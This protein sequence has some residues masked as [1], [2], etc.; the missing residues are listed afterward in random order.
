MGRQAFLPFLVLAG[1][2]MSACGS[3]DVSRALGARCED[4]G[5]CQDVC[6]PPEPDYPGGFCTASC[7]TDSQCPSGSGCV[8]R[9]DG[10]CLFLC[11]DNKD[12]EFLGETDGHSW[13]CSNEDAKGGGSLNVCV[14]Q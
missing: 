3:D 7:T 12:C 2:V 8:D 13:L 4:H 11:L 14:G 9:E 6:L 5:D 10:V 1:L